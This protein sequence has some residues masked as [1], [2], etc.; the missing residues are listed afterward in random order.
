VNNVHLFIGLCLGLLAIAG[1]QSEGSGV[2]RFVNL[3]QDAGIRP[4]ES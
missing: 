4:H 3:H 1:S 2:K